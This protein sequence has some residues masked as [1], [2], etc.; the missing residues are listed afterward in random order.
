MPKERTKWIKTRFG[1]INDNILGK[2][3]EVKEIVWP[4][5]VEE[6]E[7]KAGKLKFQLIR[8][9]EES[10]ER[11]AE[12]YVNGFDEMIGNEEK[13]WYHNPV[14]IIKKVQTGDW[15][16]YGCYLNDQLI[17]P[18]SMHIMRGNRIMHIGGGAVDP[19][20]RGE[21]ITKIFITYLD[22]IIELSN[23]QM[24]ITGTV[25]THKLSQIAIEKIGYNPMGFFIGAGFCGG[26]DGRYYRENAIWYGKFYGDGKKH[27]QSFDSM[28][29]TSKAKELTE[30]V[31]KLWG[32]EAE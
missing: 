20:Y 8:N 16:F 25:T 12:I 26:S 32:I 3:D 6:A 28:E 5:I 27:C 17:C 10:A 4:D 23:A 2:I 31:K 29:L 1:N 19:V 11:I 15:N 7:I 14:E 18:V 21:H 30:T 22:K 24:G 9:I 13:E